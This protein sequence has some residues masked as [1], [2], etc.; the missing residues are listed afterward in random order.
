[1]AADEEE[2]HVLDIRPGEYFVD[3][4][5]RSTYDLS[6][7]VL[8]SSDFTQVLL[9]PFENE[10]PRSAHIRLRSDGHAVTLPF[11]PA[12][13]D[14]YID[15]G[16]AY[17]LELGFY[18]FPDLALDGTRDMRGAFEGDINASRAGDIDA[19]VQL[20]AALRPFGWASDS[21]AF[22]APHQKIKPT[23]DH[24]MS[25]SPF[26]GFWPD[27]Q[28]LRAHLTAFADRSDAAWQSNDWD[29]INATSL[30]NIGQWVTQSGH[31]VNAQVRVRFDVTGGAA[32][33]QPSE[34]R[35]GLA[36]YL[37]YHAYPGPSF[38]HLRRCFTSAHAQNP[39][40]DWQQRYTPTQAKIIFGGLARHLFGGETLSDTEDVDRF[41]ETFAVTDTGLQWFTE[42]TRTFQQLS[43]DQQDA[44]RAHT[45]AQLEAL[46][47]IALAYD[48][49][50]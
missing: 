42:N 13:G 20:H 35:R 2:H 15:A 46:H 9:T 38:L 40:F 45:C 36:L 49:N 6:R 37:R 22:C 26:D 8:G 7:I 12:R 32:R 47:N 43:F 41:L 31:L 50:Q 10:R 21:T 29:A 24:C 1:M 18:N 44:Q 33:L 5:N 25:A 17:V 48:A 3:T 27:D 34:R 16:R 28:A 11:I 30:A 19:I 4:L 39:D 14:V 23:Y